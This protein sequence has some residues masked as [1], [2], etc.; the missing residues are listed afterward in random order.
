MSLAGSPVVFVHC[1]WLHAISWGPWE[2]LFREAGYVPL[3]PGW[4]GT[5]DTVEA[6]RRQPDQVAGESIHDVVGHYA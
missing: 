5:S 1:L 4:P 2:E 3:A 6:T